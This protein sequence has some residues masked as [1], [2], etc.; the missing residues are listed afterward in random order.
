MKILW[1]CNIMLPVIARA[2]QRECS[3]KEGWLT[4]LMDALMR[5]AS[6]VE[7]GVAFPIA[8]GEELLK[9]EVQG[10]HYYGFRENTGKPEVYDPA[11]EQDMQEILQDFQPE[12]LHCFGTE[13]PHTLAAVRAYDRPDR[14]L[15]GIQGLCAVYADA[16]MANT[17]R[18]IWHTTTF[19]DWLKKDNMQNQQEKFR[20]RGR[21]EQEAVR[22]TGHVAGRTDWDRYWTTKWNPQVQYHVLQETLRPCFYEGE[23]RYENCRRHSLFMSQGDYP[24]KGLHYM[25][26]AMADIVHQYPDAHLYVAG[27]CLLRKGPTAAL[28]ISGYG[29]YLERQIRRHNLTDHVTFLGSQSATQMKEQYLNCHAYVCVSSI[30]NS[31]NSLGEAML[32]SVPVV[33]GVVGGVGSMIRPEEGWL[34]QGFSKDEDGE[35]QRISQELGE[36]VME[37][38]VREERVAERTQKARV[39]AR[40]THDPTKNLE[41]L[42][43]LYRELTADGWRDV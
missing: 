6:Q 27:N 18:E 42:M 17:P 10:I 29:R 8:P 1:V 38:F 5:E 2:L 20:L 11:L 19:R 24:I 43:D 34:F 35:L 23:W 33:A 15:I 40:Q 14:S 31:P 21:W 26:E 13:Y 3:N 9:G 25:L 30:E 12:L 36:Q 22:L 4:G 41:Q 7:L 32:L 39:H 16:Y 28:R 37:L